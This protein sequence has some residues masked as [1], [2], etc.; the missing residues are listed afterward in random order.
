MR[1]RKQKYTDSSVTAIR[2]GSKN[3]CF[4]RESMIPKTGERGRARLPVKRQL[5][6]LAINGSQNDIVTEFLGRL[7]RKKRPEETRV[8]WRWCFVCQISPE[9]L[10]G[11]LGLGIN[12]LHFLWVIS[13][14]FLLHTDLP[15]RILR[16]FDNGQPVTVT[17]EI[18]GI[19]YNLCS[20]LLFI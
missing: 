20:R 5:V 1:E 10:Y 7:T 4:W 18:L 6:E 17:T 16:G 19:S 15:S 13:L 11:C 3:R 2:K 12:G 14:L 8:I 9:L